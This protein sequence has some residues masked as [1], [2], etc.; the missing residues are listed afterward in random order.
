M[1]TS[2]VPIFRMFDYNKAIEF[3]V[4]WLGFKIDWEQKFD[5]NSPI[6]MQISRDGIVLHLSEHHGDSAPG[7]KAYITVDDAMRLYKEICSRPYKYNH[8]GP[9][10]SSMECTLF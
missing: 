10:T 2:V 8:P 1:A 6:Y 4:N 9:G 7:S 3:Y 5:D